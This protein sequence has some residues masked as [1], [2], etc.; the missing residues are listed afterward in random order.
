ME[1]PA[2]FIPFLDTARR[3]P[4]KAGLVAAAHLANDAAT[5][6]LPGLLPF[7][8]VR[9]GLTPTEVALLVSVFAV[10]SSL[11]QPLF[12]VLADRIGGHRIGSAGLAVS[13]ALVVGLGFVSSMPW[14][15]VVLLLG[16]L[17][18]AALHPAG[19]GL[20]RA[21]ASGNPGFAVALFTAAGM[22]G[23]GLGPLLALGVISPSGF[24]GLVW[25]AAPVMLVAV[26]LA[27]LAA[28]P[29]LGA[30]GPP[31]RALDL[32]LARGPVGWLTVVALSANLVMLT[33][34]SSVPLWLMNEHG[35]SETSPVIGTTLAIFS[36]GSAAGGIAGSVLAKRFRLSHLIVG[37]LASSLVALESVLVVRPGSPQYFT[38]VGVAGALLF[39]HAPLLVVR[40]QELVPGAEATVAGILV[41]GTSAAA[42][43]V[44]A[45]FGAAQQAFG[46]GTTAAAV[47]LLVLPAAHVSAVVFRSTDAIARCG[48]E[49]CRRASCS[50]APASFDA[51]A[52]DALACT[53]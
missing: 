11:P 25:V 33:F 13:G 8:A 26:L 29:R 44:Y 24:D 17:G 7:L 32:G 6:M 1:L 5:S 27:R 38:A 42:G 46:I 19:I 28:E 52:R 12:G 48:R 37:S 45:G 2:P 30:P 40:A 31:S 10:A 36:M 35:L 9:L 43:V 21:V 18:S 15:C 41:G 51:C 4:L 53:S 22:A 47:F 3:W 20:A 34:T 49:T 23:G 39:L 16:G 14:L 50:S